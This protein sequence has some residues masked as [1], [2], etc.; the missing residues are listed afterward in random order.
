MNH[1]D[2]IIKEPSALKVINGSVGGN[3]RLLTFFSGFAVAMFHTIYPGETAVIDMSKNISIVDFTGCWL[4]TSRIITDLEIADFIPGV[5]DIRNQ[6]T[7]GN[8][9]V[10][11]IA[12][13]LAGRT[14]NRITN[15]ISLRHLGQEKT[16]VVVEI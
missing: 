8:L 12:E 14:T 7:L 1:L 9:L 3:Q 13:N 5:V 15:L 11:N 2:T 4:F 6:V 16:R 10:I